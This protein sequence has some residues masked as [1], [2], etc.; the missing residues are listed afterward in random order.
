MAQVKKTEVWDAPIEKIYDVLIDYNSYPEFVTGVDEIEVLSQDESSARV[1]YSLNIIKKVSY[2]LS[3]K[4]KRPESI[5]WTL[6]SGDLFKQND[7]SW[8]LKDLGDGKTEVTYGLEVNIKGFVPKSI[9]SAL[10]TKNLPAMMEAFEK[11]VKNS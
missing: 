5:N 1:K 4:Q 7:G 6:E 3:M 2:I 8:F 11:R 9:V 10:T